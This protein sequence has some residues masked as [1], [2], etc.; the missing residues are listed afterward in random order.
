[1]VEKISEFREKIDEL[2]IQ[3]LNI[4]EERFE[5]CKKIGKY[6]LEKNIPIEDKQREQEIIQSKCE[7]TELPE[8][9]VKR[10]FSLIF[11]ESKKL[12]RE[13]K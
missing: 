4:L 1:M 5:V 7:K 9:F 3:L 13:I 2:D 6:K 10:L 11:E 8:D 12:Q